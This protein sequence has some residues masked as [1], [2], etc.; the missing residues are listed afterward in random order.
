MTR[1]L[2]STSPYAREILYH[3]EICVYT[4]KS[5]YTQQSV[6]THRNLH[7]HSNLCIHT[8]ICKHTE[9]CV[10]ISKICIHTEPLYIHTEIC[11]YTQKSVYTHRIC[12][13][14]ETL[15]I[16]T[17]VPYKHATCKSYVLRIHTNAYMCVYTHAYIHTQPLRLVC[18][19]RA[20]YIYIKTCQH[21]SI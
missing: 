18:S 7:T 5:A 16:H 15:Y 13:H 8:E 11:V 12:I 9:I 17:Y 14:T 10:Y 21:A 3:P 6:Y 1:N 20:V 2:R 19:Y 4:Q